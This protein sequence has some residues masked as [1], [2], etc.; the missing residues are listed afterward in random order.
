MFFFIFLI[1]CF[2]YKNVWCSKNGNMRQE[3]DSD[4]AGSACAAFY[5]VIIIS[6][7]VSI[8]NRKLEH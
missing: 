2:I 7:I 5:C 6:I 4:C 3:M 1:F 8:V